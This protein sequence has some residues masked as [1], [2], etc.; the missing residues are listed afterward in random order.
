MIEPPIRMVYQGVFH[1]GA[2][3]D[4]IGEPNRR[5]YQRA[6]RRIAFRAWTSGE[7]AAQLLHAFHMAQ[8]SDLTTGDYH[9]VGSWLV[10]DPV[11]NVSAHQGQ[12]VGR[13][14]PWELA[15]AIIPGSTHA[16]RPPLLTGYYRTR[17]EEFRSLVANYAE[18]LRCLMERHHDAVRA[19]N[20]YATMSYYGDPLFA[21]LLR[22][23]VGD[24]TAQLVLADWLEERSFPHA[25]ELRSKKWNK[26]KLTEAQ[27]LDLL[28]KRYAAT[29]RSFSGRTI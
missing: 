29:R 3:A 2:N 10:A 18:S 25:A 9:L 15:N 13:A 14:G 24:R 20:L 6:A 23:A 11:G 19:G 27:L 1:T 28:S 8:S 22:A 7:P 12:Y 21:S 5:G 17:P 26:G 4:S 16:V